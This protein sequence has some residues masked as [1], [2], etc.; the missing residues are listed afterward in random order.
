MNPL[1]KPS[2]LPLHYPA[3][4]QIRN[5]HFLPAFAAGMAEELKEIDRIANNGQAQVTLVI[6]DGNHTTDHGKD[7]NKFKDVKIEL[8]KKNIQPHF[9]LNSLNSIIAWLE[10]E[11]LERDTRSVSA[12][13]CRRCSCWVR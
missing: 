2:P 6:L 7:G 3:F 9:L 13:C 5:E 8:L 10:E 4:D 1:L 12:P 11:P